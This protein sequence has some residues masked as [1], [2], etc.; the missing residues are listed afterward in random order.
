[1]IEKAFP[2]PC[3]A[4][5]GL[6]IAK[7]FWG[8]TLRPASPEAVSAQRSAAHQVHEGEVVVVAV[9]RQ[10]HDWHRRRDTPKGGSYEPQ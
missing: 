1:L 7:A 2:P 3:P 10:T 4:R 9:K 8:N 6:A 5:I